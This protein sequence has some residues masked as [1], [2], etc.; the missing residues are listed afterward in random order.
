[1][2]TDREGAMDTDT[3]AS[4]SLASA[5]ADVQRRRLTESWRAEEPDATTPHVI[6][7][8]PSYSVERSV[9]ALGINL[10]KGGTTHPY[11]ITRILPAAREGVVLHPLDRL[12]VDG[13]MGY[14]AIAHSPARRAELE[15]R[16]V[17]ALRA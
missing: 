5:F 1:M 14:T 13:R 6:I 11:G 7:G 8:L 16:T 4:A 3:P 12:A 17:S 15:E 10:R 9:Y 2:C